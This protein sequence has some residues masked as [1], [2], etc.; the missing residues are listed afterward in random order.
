MNRDDDS[1]P[2]AYHREC[3]G[4]P[5]FELEPNRA[6]EESAQARGPRP[7]SHRDLDDL[8]RGFPPAASVGSL[9]DRTLLIRDF[10]S[11]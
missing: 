4:C 11:H 1:F 6:V 10:R 7:A 8:I 5:G 9:Y 2:S 3:D